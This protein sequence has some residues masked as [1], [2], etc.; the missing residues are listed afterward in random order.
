MGPS[1]RAATVDFIF[2][3]AAKY[4][5]ALKIWEKEEFKSNSYHAAGPSRG[6]PSCSLNTHDRANT[7]KIA[8]NC[9]R[10]GGKSCNVRQVVVVE[11]RSKTV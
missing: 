6:F 4:N 1:T 10:A 9:E 8:V 3:P 5:T 2:L 7:M 11:E